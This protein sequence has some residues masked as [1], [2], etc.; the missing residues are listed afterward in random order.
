MK[1]SNVLIVPSYGAAYR[2]GES[3]NLECI[4]LLYDGYLSNEEWGEVDFNC[5]PV[6]EKLDCEKIR[7]TLV[8]ALDFT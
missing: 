7:D 5:I 2:L 6:Q 3:G 4:P 1:E 8:S